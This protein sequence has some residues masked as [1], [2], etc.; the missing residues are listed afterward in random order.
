MK[1]KDEENVFPNHSHLSSVLGLNLMPPPQLSVH[2][3][4]FCGLVSLIS[5][6]N[7]SRKLLTGSHY[8]LK[9]IASECY[10]VFLYFPKG[11]QKDHLSICT[12]MAI[13]SCYLTLKT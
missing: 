13:K 12:K 7:I 11:Y 3:F 1:W 4:W 8:I 10:V 2:S 5:L 9:S 6:E